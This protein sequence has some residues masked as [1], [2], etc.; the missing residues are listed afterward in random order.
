MCYTCLQFTLFQNET[1]QSLWVK[2]AKDYLFNSTY[3]IQTKSLVP[4]AY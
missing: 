2:W 3:S 4:L 1:K